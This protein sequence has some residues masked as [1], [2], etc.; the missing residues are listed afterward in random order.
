MKKFLKLLTV[1]FLSLFAYQLAF[2]ATAANKNTQK[3]LVQVAMHQKNLSTFVKALKAAGMVDTLKGAGPYTVFAPTN[4]AFSKLPKDTLKNLLKDKSQLASILNYHVISGKTVAK[5]IQNGP[6]NT[7]QGQPVTLS[8]ANG[9]ISVNNVKVVKSDVEASNGVINEIDAV[10]MP[11]SQNQNNQTNSVPAQTSQNDTT[12]Y[13]SDTD[14]P[15]DN[16]GSTSTTNSTS[17]TTTTPTTSPTTAPNTYPNTPDNSQNPN[18]AYPNNNPNAVTPSPSN[19]NPNAQYPTTGTPSSNTGNQ[20][21]QPPV[22]TQ[23]TTTQSNE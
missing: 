12:G 2:A 17:T 13:P 4:E 11:N 10:L 16:A 5:D 1:A 3:D 8:N 15:S 14:N 6:V 21:N 7:L 22:P 9:T 19:P 18:N 23:P 20:M